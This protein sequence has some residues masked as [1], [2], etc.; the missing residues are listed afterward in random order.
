MEVVRFVV[1]RDKVQS[2]LYTGR[3]L[4][5]QEALAA[6]LVDEVVAASDLLAR[7]HDV[8]RQLAL[9]PPPVYRLTKEALRA[10][11]LERIERTSEAADQATL[12]LWSAQETHTLIR[13]YVR[14]TLGK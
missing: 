5:P 7:A 6:G 13:E 2:L 9:I 4:L 14:K 12:E 10:E 1:P 3:S 8:A 11:A